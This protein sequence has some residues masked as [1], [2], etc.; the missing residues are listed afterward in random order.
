MEILITSGIAIFAICAYVGFKIYQ[1]LSAIMEAK[2]IHDK[3]VQDHFWSTQ[4]SFEE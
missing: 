1:E 4:Q 2:K 3:M